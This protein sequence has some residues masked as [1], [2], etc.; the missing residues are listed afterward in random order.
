MSSVLCPGVDQSCCIVLYRRRR[1]VKGWEGNGWIE[2]V[3]VLPPLYPSANLGCSTQGESPQSFGGSLPTST[4]NSRI[5]GYH[6]GY[7]AAFV[8]ICLCSSASAH[9]RAFPHHTQVLST[10]AQ[11]DWAAR[12]AA[13][14]EARAPAPDVR[15]KSCGLASSGPL[16]PHPLVNTTR[17]CIDAVI[18][19]PP[20]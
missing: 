8:F 5:A 6:A 15:P 12:C 3:G 14:W 9:L 19:P 16:G 2:V 10:T 1:A 11:R 18:L 13:V 17:S 20:E 4:N 7:P